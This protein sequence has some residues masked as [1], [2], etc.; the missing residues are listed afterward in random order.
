MLAVMLGVSAVS[1]FGYHWAP[2]A[3]PGERLVRM[4]RTHCAP[5]SPCAS[6][7]WGREAA[8]SPRGQRKLL[9]VTLDVSASRVFGYPW[10]RLVR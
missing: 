9:A 2:W 3:G 6:L 4:D 10:V 8:G 1:V 5:S 7:G